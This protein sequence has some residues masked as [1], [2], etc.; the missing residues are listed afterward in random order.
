MPITLEQSEKRFK[1]WFEND[2]FLLCLNSVEN[3]L[4][5][6]S[7]PMSSCYYTPHAHEHCFSV[8]K[9]VKALVNNSFI[10]LN[11]LEK[12]LLFLAIWTHDLGML[13]DIAARY[14]G[15]DF[16]PER[17]RDDH[18]KTTAAYLLDLFE[19]HERN[20]NIFLNPNNIF[21]HGM[22]KNW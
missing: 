17:K 8:E 1:K 14:L 19:K 20:E 22:L 16:S 4:L 10:K 11:E 12:F 18:D 3:H 15:D 2:D 7:K 9:I 13:D 21:T 6:S 5:S